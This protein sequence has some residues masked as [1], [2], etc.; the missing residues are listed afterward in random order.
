MNEEQINDQR[1][2]WEKPLLVVLDVS[3]TEFSCIKLGD[4]NDGEDI[5]LKS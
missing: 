2:V 1:M 5:C 3:L 4:L